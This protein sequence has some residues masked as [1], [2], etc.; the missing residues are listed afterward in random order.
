[1]PNSR[2]LIR[3]VRRRP[4]LAVSLGFNLVLAA[5]STVEHRRHDSELQGALEQFWRAV[6]S[7]ARLLGDGEAAVGI[8]VDQRIAEQSLLANHFALVRKLSART[9]ADQGFDWAR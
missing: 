6:G 8:D 3:G 4:L 5:V 1:M 7:D 9:S 2:R